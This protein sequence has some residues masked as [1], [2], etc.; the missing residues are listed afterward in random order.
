L[1]PVQILPIDEYLL[2]TRLQLK[3]KGDE[4][5]PGNLHNPIYLLVQELQGINPVLTNALHI[6][7]SVIINWLKL[8]NKRQV[9]YMAGHKYISSTEAYA[10]Q[11]LDTL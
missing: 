8:H 7:G 4:L 3:P 11:D 1:Q 6:M 5:F 2:H 10:V 9:Q